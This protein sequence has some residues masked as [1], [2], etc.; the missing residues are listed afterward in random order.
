MKQSTTNFR[1]AIALVLGSIS[2]LVLLWLLGNGFHTAQ[3][4]GP[5]TYSI[6]YVAPGGSCG[7]G[8]TPCYATV[9][10]AV[11]AADEPGDVIKV[12]AGTYTGVNNYGGL[13]QVIYISKTVTIRGGY[14]S[15]FIDPPD[16]EDNPTTLD[17]QGHGRVLYIYVEPA[18]IEGL[19]ITGGD[20]TGLGGAERH[21]EPPADAGG[22]VYVYGSGATISHCVVYSNTASTDDAGYGG[23]LYLYSWIGKLTLS[24]NMIV[25]NT[26]S[27]ARGAYGGG[28][29]VRF[30][31]NATLSGNTVRGNTA[32]TAGVGTGGGL[33]LL[34]SNRLT[35]S[36]NTIVSNTASTAGAGYGG[37]L[38]LR[39]CPDA[40]LSDNMI[41]SNTASTVQA[42]YGG[43]FAFAHM[44]NSTLSRNTIVSNAATLSSAATGQGGGLWVHEWSESLTLVNNLV[45]GN[46]ATTQGSGL[47]FEGPSR[48]PT[49][50]RL[51]H[52]TIAD[53]R[54]SGQGVFAGEGTTLAFTNTIIAGH[55]GVGITVTAGSTAT[56]E[57]TLWYNSG[58]D[59]GGGGAI[60]T[61][62]I[63]VHDDPGFVAPS[64]WDYH[65]AASSPALDR[66]VDTGVRDDI[67]GDLRPASTG[68]DLGADE[69]TLHTYLPVVMQDWPQP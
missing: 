31:D 39:D 20:A 17:A 56:L 29:L 32:S 57:A 34:F 24:G 54:S 50:V 12:A 16:A 25:S 59:T 53:N 23:G 40:T 49:S 2:T 66:G 38:F 13:A 33:S 47:W 9:Q 46:H 11:D 18:V 7:A 22:G 45:A 41:V 1:I 63:N 21:M 42:G 61:G 44:L 65:L 28:L 67:D 68:Y 4:Q 5:D 58:P 26:A 8:F 10:A 64:V 55:N 60:A 48:D 62:T 3:A 52:T 37:G 19:R 51:L 14:T 35:L 36:G 6:Y 69:Y 30:S 43:G 15:A 27:T